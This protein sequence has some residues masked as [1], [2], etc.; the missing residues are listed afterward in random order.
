MNHP[1]SI[2]VSRA[3]L[4]TARLITIEASTG[5][6]DNISFRLDSSFMSHSDIRGVIL[7]DA[8]IAAS[9][10]DGGTFDIHVE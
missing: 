3:T 10:T 2:Q 7:A 6:T 5:I 1:L 4:D 9:S 8:S